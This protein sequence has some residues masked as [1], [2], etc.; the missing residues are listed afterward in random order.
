MDKP[1]GIDPLAGK[2]LELLA[3]KPEAAEIVLGGYFALQ[4]YAAYRRTHDIDAWWKTRAHA[5]TEQVIRTAMQQV[6]TAEG[7]ELRE[8]RF[9]ET[10]SWELIRQ[11]QRQFSFQIRSEERRV[12]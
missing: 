2:V 3:G 4:H 9:G 6:A 7:L 5:A 10:V 8:R 11:G 1:P 12:G